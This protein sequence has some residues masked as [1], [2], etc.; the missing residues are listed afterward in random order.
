MDEKNETS[1]QGTAEQWANGITLKKTTYGHTWSIAVRAASNDPRD[2][3]YALTA[4]IAI[5]RQLTLRYPDTK[6]R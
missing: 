6:K 5:D 4:A 3:D 1:E 2:L